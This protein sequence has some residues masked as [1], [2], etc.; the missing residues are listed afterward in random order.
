MGVVS[1]GLIILACTK[2]LMHNYL[3]QIVVL[4]SMGLIIFLFVM[5]KI[6]IAQLLK[7][8]TS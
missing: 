6:K 8:K 4:A 3:V 5:K 7:L 1:A 2:T